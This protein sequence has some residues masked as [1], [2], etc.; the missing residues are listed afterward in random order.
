MPKGYVF[1]PVDKAVPIVFTET[2]K[3][4]DLKLLQELVGGYIEYCKCE[5][6]GRKS[7]MIVDE[8]GLIKQKPIN[9]RATRM[10]RALPPAIAPSL[11]VGDAVV[12]VG[13]R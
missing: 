6:N 1:V 8:E 4:P 10:V 12:L 5:F 7:T 13:Y 9:G 3:S 11:I 2:E